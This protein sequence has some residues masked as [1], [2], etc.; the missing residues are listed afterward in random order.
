MK[1]SIGEV[2]TYEGQTVS[3]PSF[4]LCQLYFRNSIKQHT[5]Q[6]ICSI[7][8]VLFEYTVCLVP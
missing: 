4:V 8:F 2:F 1:D 7:E 3:Q 6:I 5:S